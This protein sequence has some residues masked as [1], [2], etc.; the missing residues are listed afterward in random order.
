MFMYLHTQIDVDVKFDWTIIIEST[1][2]RS[3][4]SIFLLSIKIHDTSLTSI[5]FIISH[6]YIY[7]NIIFTT[8]FASIIQQCAHALN[9]EKKGIIYDIH[10]NFL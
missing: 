6:I 10:H 1:L 4:L 5:K 9:K 8:S 7:T 3:T 2:R